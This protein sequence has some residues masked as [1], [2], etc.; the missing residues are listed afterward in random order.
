MSND[1]SVKGLPGIHVPDGA[2]YDEG[3]CAPEKRGMCL[4]RVKVRV[5]KKEACD[6]KCWEDIRQIKKIIKEAFREKK[7]YDKLG[8]GLKSGGKKGGGIALGAFGCSGSPGENNNTIHHDGSVDVDVSDATTDASGLDDGGVPPYFCMTEGREGIEDSYLKLVNP[9]NQGD[10]YAVAM[11]HD[12]SQN[13]FMILC[14]YSN[15][16][17]LR[18][19]F[20]DSP[21]LEMLLRVNDSSPAPENGETAEVHPRNVIMVSP[22]GSKQLAVVPYQQVNPVDPGN[23][24]GGLL[25]Y[26]AGQ[27]VQDKSLSI[28]IIHGG[29]PE[30]TVFTYTGPVGVVLSQ[31]RVWTAPKNLNP[32][33]NEPII[34]DIVGMPVVDHGGLLIF[35]D[36]VSLCGEGYRPTAVAKIN[37]TLIAGVFNG[38]AAPSV[39]DGKKPKFGI[40]NAAAA[41]TFNDALLTVDDMGLT[42]SWQLVSLPNAAKTYDNRNF[43]LAAENPSTGAYKVLSIHVDDLSDVA[44]SSYS[45]G[46]D[47]IPATLPNP[48]YRAGT[49]D[50]E[51]ISTGPVVNIAVDGARAY[52][53]TAGDG[54]NLGFM[55][56]F[57]VD[58]SNGAL[59]KVGVK[60]LGANPGVASVDPLT[61]D[62]YQVV[63][64]AN[65][66]E[67][68]QTSPYVVRIKPN[69]VDWD[70]F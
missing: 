49:D 42:Q 33:T 35:G 21:V 16:R 27:L 19:A 3:Q 63:R 8:S 7:W 1:M 56:V 22:D 24:K 47:D 69:D 6:A 61:G 50:P 2:S 51:T 44:N 43:V 26:D 20:G 39:V 4:Q 52:V 29:D 64:R 13:K 31:G 37:D 65:C 41:Q 70:S 9:D 17:I 10:C 54:Q 30:G 45:I 36:E 62:I 15:N 18:S 59:T 11:S 66:S 32:D 5:E 12:D 46:S 23:V 60:G 28:K 55:F 25:L 68:D 40:F 58:V 53:T 38:V 57:D 14:S 67:G 48:A 34:S